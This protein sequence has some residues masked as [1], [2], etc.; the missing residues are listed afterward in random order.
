[1]STDDE[2]AQTLEARREALAALPGVVGTALGMGRDGT[3]TIRIY[4]L[5]DDVVAEVDHLARGLLPGTPIEVLVTG[6]P[7]EQH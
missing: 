4:V 3:A 1:M 2:V 7:T 5:R 6:R